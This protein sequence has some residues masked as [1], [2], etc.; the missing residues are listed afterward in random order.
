MAP[1]YELIIWSVQDT[2]ISMSEPQVH[3]VLQG[4]RNVVEN[5]K[6]EM[7]TFSLRTFF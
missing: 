7:E 6:K 3:T 4:H 5:L 1:M 2:S